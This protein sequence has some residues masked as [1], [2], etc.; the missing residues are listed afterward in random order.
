MGVGNAT[1][2]DTECKRSE[3]T[4]CSMFFPDQP[5]R[6]ALAYTHFDVLRCRWASLV[7]SADMPNPEPKSENP[8]VNQ[9]HH[10]AEQISDQKAA[11]IFA[12]LLISDAISRGNAGL[13]GITQA[14]S[15][16]R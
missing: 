3:K 4:G 8:L 15:S 11:T 7:S 10:L 2:G 6:F 14:I 13:A 16:R 1:P 5:L 9:A 12:A